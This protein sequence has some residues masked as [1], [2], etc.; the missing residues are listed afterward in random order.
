MRAR[1]K[2]RKTGKHQFDGPLVEAVKRDSSATEDTRS[3]NSCI[4][5]RKKKQAAAAPS[6]DQKFYGSL[7]DE[8]LDRVGNTEK[9][10]HDMMKYLDA[11]ENMMSGDDLTHIRKMLDYTSQSVKHHSTAY[12]NIKVQVEDM[13]NDAKGALSKL[14][15]HNDD[16]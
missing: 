15:K 7:E 16:I 11:V 4:P 3:R 9:D 12:S 8:L 6:D 10:L 14:A 1:P 13:N 2:Q 5:G